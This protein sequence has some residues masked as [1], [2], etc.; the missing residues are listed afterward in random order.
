MYFDEA[1]QAEAEIQ[2]GRHY[3]NQTSNK[4]IQAA[5]ARAAWRKRML[6]QAEVLASWTWQEVE[7]G[8]RA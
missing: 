5:E 4:H 6:G 1:W 7:R 8:G 3:R 2:C